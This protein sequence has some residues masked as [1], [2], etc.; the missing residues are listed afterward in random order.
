MPGLEYS[1]AKYSM[2]DL[3]QKQYTDKRNWFKLCVIQF[4][5]IIVLVF[6]V[7]LVAMI[8]KP[9]PWVV[10]VDEHGYEVSI[11]VAG[12]QKIDQR[13]MIAR[14]GR[15]I[16]A[17]RTVISDPQGQ[18]ALLDWAFTAVPQNS[19]AYSTLDKF[20][21]ENDPYKRGREGESVEVQVNNILPKSDNTYQADWTET[22]SR[23]GNDPVKVHWTG[24]FVLAVNPTKDVKQ[25]I[26]NPL[27]IF[28]TEYSITQEIQ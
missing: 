23:F 19:K 17:T 25:I 11:G 4:I 26:K 13:V 15:F 18:K 5:V 7:V 21:N 6:A 14:V 22:T 9:Y 16:Q 10:Q 1:K 27:G 8:S 12:Q 2:Q 3:F 24:L 28:I 20:Y